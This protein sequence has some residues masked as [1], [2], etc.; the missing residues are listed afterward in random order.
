MKKCLLDTPS[1]PSKTPQYGMIFRGL[2]NKNI[3]FDDTSKKNN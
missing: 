1:T 2:D 3:P